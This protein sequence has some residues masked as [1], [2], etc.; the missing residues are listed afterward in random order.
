MPNEN[1]DRLFT[2]ER[3]AD[4]DR[5]AAEIEA[6]NFYTPDE[7]AVELAKRRDQWLRQN[8]TKE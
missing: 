5:A 7:A 3:L 1:L 8:Q 6:G 2:P 4:I